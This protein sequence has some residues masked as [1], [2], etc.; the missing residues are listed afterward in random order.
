ME[1]IVVGTLH[2]INIFIKDQASKLW[3]LA[4]DRAKIWEAKEL[5]KIS[6]Q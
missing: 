5:D 2:A 3:R 4:A 1:K 6:S